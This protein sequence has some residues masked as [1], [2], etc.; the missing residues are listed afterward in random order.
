MASSFLF[1]HF[2][3]SSIGSTSTATV[4]SYPS[5]TGASH[6]YANAVSTS[7]TGAAY[8]V[9]GTTQILPQPTRL[10]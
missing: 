3:N 8:P 4:T 6:F 9:A 1:L 5:T 2:R 7:A 10:Y